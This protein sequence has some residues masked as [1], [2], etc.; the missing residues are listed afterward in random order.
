MKIQDHRLIASYVEH[1]SSPNHSGA[2]ATGEPDTLILHYTAMGSTASAV[3]LLMDPRRQVSAHLVV[4]RDGRIWQLLPFDTIGWHA[5]RSRWGDRSEFNRCS[6]GIEIDNAGRLHE[7]DGKLYS[8]FEREI[9]RQEAVQA[10]HRHETEVCWWQK[11]PDLQLQRVEQLC[12]VLAATY[13]LQLI[14]GHEEVAPQRKADPGPAFPLDALRHRI[15]GQDTPP[16]TL[17]TI[18]D[19]VPTGEDT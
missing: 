7:R 18:T 11:F 4:G 17:A 3:R 15:L 14:L 1:L 16:S 19:S 6:I 5:G 2:L 12:E 13:S 9:A 10:T 8:W